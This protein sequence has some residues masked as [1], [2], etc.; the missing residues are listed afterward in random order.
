MTA[1][2]FVRHWN[3]R[4]LAASAVFAWVTVV[5]TFMG[6][7]YAAAIFILAGILLVGGMVRRQWPTIDRRLAALAILMLALCWASSLWSIVPDRTVHGALQVS[8]IFF[9]SLVLL[10]EAGT[11][12]EG[13]DTIF[14]VSLAGLT[15]GAALGLFDFL[16]D[17]PIMSHVLSPHAPDYA[18]GTKMDR[19]LS[20]LVFLAWP[21]LAFAWQAGMRVWALGAA[22]ILIAVIS[23]SYGITVQLSLAVGT[24]ALALAIIAP[25]LVAIGLSLA[26]SLAALATPIFALG[27]G[28]RLL[29]LAARIK[30]SAVHRLEIWDYMSRRTFEKPLIGWGWWTAHALPIHPDELARYQ[31]VTRD[32]SPHPHGNWMQ[33]WVE[34]GIVGVAIGLAF[35]LLVIWRAWRLP[36]L[37]RPF[38]LACCASVFTISLASFD[39]ASDSWWAA[40]SATALLFTI[41]PK[42]ATMSGT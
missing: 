11:V 16:A 36:G 28:E 29:P 25:R 32:G 4:V 18:K 17:F 41:V 9:G 42:P 37:Y 35:A 6:A 34:T 38:A 31:Y 39:L 2:Q 3:W 30:P 24:L 26:V 27:L 19:G 40:L 23:V 20:Y 5:G 14:R 22:A 21:L 10:G 1:H 13:V 7:T 15:L 12:T 8:V 33:L